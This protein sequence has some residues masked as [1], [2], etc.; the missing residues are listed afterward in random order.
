MN[1]HHLPPVLFDS[2]TAGTAPSPAAQKVDFGLIIVLAIAAALLIPASRILAGTQNGDGILTALISTQKLT[3]YFWE[4]DR[5]LN[6]IP[7]LASPISHV[8]WNLRLQIFLRAFFAYLAPIGIL[9]F[10]N[11]SPRFLILATALANCLLALLFSEQANFN[12]YVEHNPFG[13]SLVLFA[14]SLFFLQRGETTIRWIL[15]AA[16]VGFLAYATNLALLV[17]SFPLIALALLANTLPRKRLAVFFAVNMLSVALAYAHSKVAGGGTTP[18]TALGISW[19]TIQLG[20]ASVATNLS[21]KTLLAVALVAAALG[22]YRRLPF[23]WA[24]L[25]LMLGSTALIGVLSC[26]AWPQ[27]NEH[28][29][30]Y[31]ITFIIAIASGISYLLIAAIYPWINGRLSTLVLVSAALAVEFVVAMQGI[32]PNPTELLADTWRQPSKLIANAVIENDARLVIG[33]FWSGWPAVFASLEHAPDRVRGDN[34]IYGVAFRAGALRNRIR[35]LTESTPG[36]ARA[37]CIQDSVA[38]CQK[39]ASEALRLNT[40]IDPASI[41]K[42]DV[43][44]KAMLLMD[45]RFVDNALSSPEQAKSNLALNGEPVFIP[46]SHIVRI[47]VEFSNLGSRQFSSHEYPA[48]RLGAQLFNASNKIEQIDFARADIPDLA[49]GSQASVNIDLKSDQIDG[50]HVRI[51]AVQEGVAWFDRFGQKGIELGPFHDCLNNN[52]PWLCDS[53]Q[54]PLQAGP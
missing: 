35:R 11:R 37:L 5:F 31:Y 36:G 26:S 51:L 34:A 30:R 53:E 48:I 45:V 14:L 8:E 17:I 19:Q 6:F 46:A 28:H 13:T 54:R 3:W 29:I 32:S 20:Y 50:R 33:D 21:W 1:N 52:K 4:Q 40:V 49:P 38:E 9:Y 15:S 42:I 12:L 25:L 23:S 22:F 43:A 10:F 39:T 24:V 7:A 18:F 41:R 16:T 27:I 44:G 47:P 2:L